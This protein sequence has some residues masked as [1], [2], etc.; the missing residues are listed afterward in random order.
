MYRYIH[1]CTNLRH[2]FWDGGSIIRSF[3]WMNC[4][5]LI[6]SSFANSEL[7]RIIINPTYVSHCYRKNGNLNT[8]WPQVLVH[9]WSRVLTWWSYNTLIN[10]GFKCDFEQLYT[11]CK[12]NVIVATQNRAGKQ[13][14]G[15][16]CFTIC[17][18]VRFFHIILKSVLMSCR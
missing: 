5:S 16:W 10:K 8:L 7:S 14:P 3:E 18:F 2:L 12:E 9:M 6:K 4:S 15:Q 17:L 1:F 11:I 13:S